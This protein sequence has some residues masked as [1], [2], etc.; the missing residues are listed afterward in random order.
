MKSYR[1]D[2]DKSVIVW[3]KEAIAF[4]K[5]IVWKKHKHIYIYRRHISWCRNLHQLY[6]LYCLIV[7]NFYLKSEVINYRKMLLKSQ[8]REQQ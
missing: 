7:P 6:E 1:I 8:L 5:N 4:V 3:Q 2:L